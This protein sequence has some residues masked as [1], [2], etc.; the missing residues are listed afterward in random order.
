M[1]IADHDQTLSSKVKEFLTRKLEDKKINIKKFKRKR[2]IIKFL[3]YSTTISSIINS[4]ILASISTMIFIPPIV[5]TILATTSAILTTIST[6]FNFEEKNIQ[7]SRDIEKLN[8]INKKIDYIVS[9]NGNLTDTE[10]LQI[11]SEF[12]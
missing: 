10:Y 4:S 8:K 5:I 7:L 2:N 11:M 12:K 6:K 9:C 3:Y 1:P